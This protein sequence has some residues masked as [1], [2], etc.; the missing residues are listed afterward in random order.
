MRLRSLVITPLLCLAVLGMTKPS[1]LPADEFARRREVFL[2]QL[3]SLNACAILHSA[4]EVE[5]NHDVDYPYRQD[6]GLIYLSGWLYP[7]TILLLTPQ[8]AG[9]QQ[10]EVT[11][12]VRQRDPKSEI[13]TGPRYGIEEALA[14]PGV[15]RAL[16]YEAFF[17]SLTSLTRGYQRWVTSHGNDLQFEADLLQARAGVRGDIPILQDAENLLKSQRLIKSEQEIQTLE[18]AIAITGASLVD[19]FK[20]IPTLTREYEVQAEIEYGFAKRGAASLGFPSIVGAGKNGTYLHYEANRGSLNA[21][22]LILL[23]VGAEWEYYSAD[24]TR[25]V[26]IDGTFSPPQTAI[27][28]LVLKAQ[29]AAIESIRPGVSW[30]QPHTIVVRVL[31]EGLVTLGLLEGQVDTLITDGSYRR[32]FMHG[33]SHWLGLDVHDTGGYNGTDNSPLLLEPGM[34]LTV[35]P[36]LYIQ[37][38]EDIDPK[39]WNIGV[40][41]ED[42]VLVTHKGYRILSQD[43]PRKIEE[44]EKLMQP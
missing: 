16:P 19:A 9:S 35:E 23:D 8:V 17:D 27:Y 33:T 7:E 1:Q 38:A 43:I 44:I 15:D 13:W 2:D 10:A 34:V 30:R 25:T 6:S 29:T 20:V 31:T 32:F 5:R 24:I 40:R 14:L 39:W 12:F 42:D 41:I 11:L 18:Q 37:E 21:Q 36:G 28:T 26:P 22:D 3:R 4:P